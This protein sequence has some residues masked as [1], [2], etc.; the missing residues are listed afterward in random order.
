VQAPR[1]QREVSCTRFV[2]EEPL[3]RERPARRTGH[4]DRRPQA[5]PTG[6]TIARARVR[7]HRSRRRRAW[8]RRP[9]PREQS[10]EPLQRALRFPSA[11]GLQGVLQVPAPRRGRGCSRVPS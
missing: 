8:R 4:G 9:Y 11:T 7:A 6:R 2:D 1:L 10:C 3:I 5:L